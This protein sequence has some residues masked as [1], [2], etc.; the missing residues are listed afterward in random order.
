MVSFGLHSRIFASRNS[1]P[2]ARSHFHSSRSRVPRRELPAQGKIFE[3]EKTER[4]YFQG[5]NVRFDS[6]FSTPWK[7]LL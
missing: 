2:V 6:I 1:G 3:M 4:I 7:K 5:E